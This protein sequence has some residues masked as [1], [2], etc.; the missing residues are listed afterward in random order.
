MVAENLISSAILPLRTSDT[1]EEAIQV[2][3]DFYVRHLPIVNDKQLLGVVSEDDI[4]LHDVHEAVGSYALSLL[5]PYVKAQDHIYEIM[6][7]L[8][9]NSLTIIPVVDYDN[10]Y[11]GMIAMEDVLN[12]FAKTGTFSE[13]GSIVVLEMHRRDYSLAEIS[14]IVESES[15]AVLSSFITS[16]LETPRIDV[17]VK[18]NRPNIQNILASFERFEYNI[19]ASFNESDYLDSLQ[20][21][22]DSLMSYLN[23]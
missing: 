16:D 8:S 18:I 10:N 21:R 7:L 3:E 17:T 4:L 6:R 2:M 9:E 1:G 11:I 19:K 23:V 15:A 5:K 14:R 22:Y 13:Q 12:Y 20:E